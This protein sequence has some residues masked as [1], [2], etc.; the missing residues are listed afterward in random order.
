MKKI[1]IFLI[2]IIFIVSIIVFIR[3]ANNNR[4]ANFKYSEKQLDN[5]INDENLEEKYDAYDENQEDIK[6][7]LIDNPEELEENEIIYNNLEYKENLLYDLYVP[8][9][10][11]NLNNQALMLFI[12]GGAWDSG[13][14]TDMDYFCKLF[15]N[16]GYITATMEYS[17][18]NDKGTV[19]FN[20]ILDDISDCM[21]AIKEK[22]QELGIDI[23]Q[24][25]LGGYSAGGHLA[26][27]YSYS[28][29]DFSP[30]PLK[31]VFE[32]AG[33][34]DFHRDSWSQH[35]DEFI[36]DAIFRYT[37]TKITAN[38]FYSDSTEKLIN[39]ISPI[40][41]VSNNTIPSI[42]GYG[43]LDQDVLPIQCEKLKNVL[44]E[45]KVKYEL[46]NFTNSDHFLYEDIEM[47]SK[48]VFKVLQYARKYFGY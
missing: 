20:D 40:Y 28:R 9:K 11:N 6:S 21:Y 25:A 14:K 33:P 29:A 36:C 1:S 48:V 4:E 44:E 3:F 12:H 45:N 38:E 26:L 37:G 43:D 15:S 42:L 34:T 47:Q 39:S 16:L 30:L 5:K 32:E 22:G 23:T 17:F 10:I 31:F 19:T 13:N 41:Y 8:N 7:M 18:V 24:A 46:F 35:D 2:L 27:L